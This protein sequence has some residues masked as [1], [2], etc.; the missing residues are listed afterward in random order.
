[1]SRFRAD[2]DEASRQNAKLYRHDNFLF[3]ACA[4]SDDQICTDFPV[5]TDRK[6]AAIAVCCEACFASDVAE[7]RK[8]RKNGR[9]K[10]GRHTHL[11]ETGQYQRRR[12]RRYGDICTDREAYLSAAGISEDQID[13]NGYLAEDADFLSTENRSSLPLGITFRRVGVQDPLGK[14]SVRTY[15]FRF[16]ALVADEAGAGNRRCCSLK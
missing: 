4:Q 10:D 13:R 15:D 2:F 14:C 1:M 12:W 11:K 16:A 5:R 9:V 6:V 7:F 3:A 8:S